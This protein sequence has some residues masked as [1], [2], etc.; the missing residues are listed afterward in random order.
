MSNVMA[1]SANCLRLWTNPGI[2]D[3]SQSSMHFSLTS[4][5]ARNCTLIHTN[6]MGRFSFSG[7]LLENIPVD[8]VNCGIDPKEFSCFCVVLV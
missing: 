5:E 7:C 1:F 4:L 2:T 8:N 6:L 3:R